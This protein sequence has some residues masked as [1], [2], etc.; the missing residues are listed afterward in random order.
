MIYVI[1]PD[2]LNYKTF[3]IEGKEIRQKLGKDSIFHFD[4]RP[5]KYAE[6]WQEINIEF[7]KVSGRNKGEMP[8]I[9][10][11]NGR[12]F[13]NEKAY[14][15]LHDSLAS[16]GEFLPV[17]FDSSRGFL[18]NPLTIAENL[19][20]LDKKL[21][22]KNEYNELQSIAFHEEKL[23]NIEIFRAEFDNYMGVY[24]QDNLK[25]LT[26]SLHLKG[27]IFSTDLGNIFPEDAAAKSPNTH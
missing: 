8:D 21:S 1:Q 19:N 22:T 6:E 12:L 14:A 20:A 11:R 3:V 27:L 15:G 23:D 5:K 4:Q 24:C 2:V 25:S 26:E 17:A 10:L 9:I 13:L 7:A 16:H 18:F